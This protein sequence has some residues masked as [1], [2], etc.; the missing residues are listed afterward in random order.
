[1]PKTEKKAPLK[2]MSKKVV[3]EEAAP[4]VIP[5]AATMAENKYAKYDEA[6]EYDYY[7]QVLRQALMAKN[8]A[9][10]REV[11]Q[12]IQN[13]RASGNVGKWDV[14]KIIPKDYQEKLTDGEIKAA[15]SKLK[16]IG[17]QD[18]Y[19]RFQELRRRP[20]LAGTDYGWMERSDFSDYSPRD[21]AAEK[22]MSLATNQGGYYRPMI[23]NGLLTRQANIPEALSVMRK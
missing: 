6:A 4:I 12:N 15:L 13:A 19:K 1:M 5:M 18:P 21:L 9:K 17:G 3:V 2:A 7:D 11:T 23:K 16:P 14:Q 22:V 8:P 20:Q 10:F